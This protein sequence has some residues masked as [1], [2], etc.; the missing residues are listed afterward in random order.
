MARWIGGTFA[1]GVWVV[2]GVFS[3]PLEAC[4]APPL[5]APSRGT[6]RGV[7][8]REYIGSEENRLVQF[9]VQ[10]LFAAQRRYNPVVFCGPTGTGK[11]LLAEGLA[12]R[13]RQERPGEPLIATCGADFAR[14]YAYALDTDSLAD[15]RDKLAAARFFVVDDLQQ[16]RQKPAA[17]EELARLL[18]RLLDCGTAV[19]LATSQPP[20]THDGLARRLRSRLS[21]G[22]TVPLLAPGAPARRVLL[23]QLAEKHAVCLSEEALDLLAAG[24]EPE[25][26]TVPQLNH[27]ILQ[28][29]HAARVEDAD[30]ARDTDWIRAFLEDQARARQPSFRV[31]AG[32]TARYFNVT[33]QQLRGPSRRS[34]VVRA[35]GVAML[36]ARTLTGR[37][38]ELIGQYFGNRD[39]T[40]VLHACRKTESLRHTDLAIATAVDQLSQELAG[41]SSPT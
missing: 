30:A 25:R 24:T 16:L 35:R 29:G 8:V 13:W 5:K 20:G 36:L 18:D 4:S 27:A 19:L 3:I 2:S 22:L 9:A 1:D 26:L 11:T 21:S 15:F 10:E 6:P 37:S 40:T 17:Q 14:S 33:M 23:Q 32:K 7:A 38:L 28:L 31:I 12:E 34:Q 41:P 39:H